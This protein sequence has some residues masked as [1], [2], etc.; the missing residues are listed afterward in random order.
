MTGNGEIHNN[1]G[2]LLGLPIGGVP[3]KLAIESFS[4]GSN[5]EGFEEEWLYYIGSIVKCTVK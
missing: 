2:Y 4:N 3:A 5:R 1:L